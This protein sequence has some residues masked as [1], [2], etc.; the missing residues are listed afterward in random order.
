MKIKTI[1]KINEEKCW[2]GYKRNYDVPKGQQGSCELK[3]D[4]LEEKK[5]RKKKKKVVMM[6]G[7]LLMLLVLS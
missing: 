2:D 3:E 4:E 5:K 1:K 7:L 6:F